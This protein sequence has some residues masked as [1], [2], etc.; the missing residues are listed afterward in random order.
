MR[1]DGTP[2]TGFPGFRRVAG[3]RSAVVHGYLDIDI[4][5]VH[6]LLN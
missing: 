4:A 3:F 6:R 2:L 5:I 1:R